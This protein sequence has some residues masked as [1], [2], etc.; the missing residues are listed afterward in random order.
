[1][2]SSDSKTREEAHK[3]LTQIIGK[4]LGENWKAWSE[5]WD[6]NK[7]DLFEKMR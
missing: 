1:M 7:E 5:W 6:L 2:K 3:Q 4:D